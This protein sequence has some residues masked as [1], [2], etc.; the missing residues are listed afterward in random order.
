MTR[1][2]RIEKPPRPYLPPSMAGALTALASA[3]G[4]LELGWREYLGDDAPSVGFSL[5]LAA[6]LVALGLLALLGALAVRRARANNVAGG[7]NRRVQP[8]Q[9]IAWMGIGLLVGACSA[10][11]G[12]TDRRRAL[13]AI[14]AVPA[15][16]LTFRIEADGTKNDYGMQYTAQ[17]HT[18][19]G[20]TVGRVRLACDEAFDLGTEVSVIGRTSKLDGSSWGRSRYMAGSVAEVRV[21]RI[22]SSRAYALNPIIRAREMILDAI[23]PSASA[24]RALIAGIVCGR[25]TELNALE[26]SDAFARTGTSHLV[27][28]SGSHLALVSALGSTVL[29]TL[30]ASQRTRGVLL[31]LLMGAYVLFTGGAAS[32]LRS[33][34]M[35][36][37]SLVA[38]LSG[39][40]SHGLS[41][42]A[43]SAIGLVFLDAGIAYDL[44]FQLSAMS[45]LFIQLFGR[46]LTY[47]I[48]RL[49]APRTLAEA[50]ALTVSAQ[51]A[52]LPLT[53]PIFGTCS[54]VAPIANLVLGPIMSALLVV[55]LVSMPIV[56][57]VPLLAPCMIPAEWL[58]Q[59]S[60][61][62]AEAF[63]EVP[64]ASIAMAPSAL[65]APA[66][67]VTAAIVYLLW[68]DVRRRFVLIAAAVCLGTAGGY[69]CF[70]TCFAP[71]SITVLDVGQADAILIR[72]GSSAVLV[73]AGVDEQVVS[74]LA[75]NAVFHLDAV[76]ITHWDRDHCGGLPELLNTVPVDSVMV[77]QGAR[78]GMPEDLAA[79]SLPVVQEMS[80]G[81]AMIVGEFTCEMVW[82]RAAVEGSE[83][84]ESLVLVARYEQAERQL[85]VVLTGDTEA[86]EAIAY[87]PIVGDIDVLKIGH[88]GSSKSLNAEVLGMLDPEL[89]IASAGAD[90]AYGHPTSACME[91]V[92]QYG[93]RFLCTKD[94]GDV[95]VEPDEDGIRVH[96]EQSAVAR[97]VFPARLPIASIASIG[98]LVACQA[99]INEGAI[100]RPL[101]I[102]RFLALRRVWEVSAHGGIRAVARL[103]DRW[104]GRG[105]TRFGGGALEE[106]SCI[107]R[108]ARFQPR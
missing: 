105:Q 27:A 71:P 98:I 9:M 81:D 41:G 1:G 62:L 94:V 69:V 67:Y 49:G 63:S 31:A 107:E 42:L 96:V 68:L 20:T 25:T 50:L 85:A 92:A 78:A 79:L 74:A 61:F 57:F 32:A 75:R 34:D 24:A 60:V 55:G 99:T 3:S 23:D 43:L 95:R 80:V 46:Y 19:D 101:N 12:V 106:S 8:W 86:D 35:V 89:A 11:W 91:A 108:N 58:A 44:G 53:I 97:E 29:S 56:A 90:N 10:A 13:E 47:G 5:A 36:V 76:V 7:S 73:D 88:H 4:V 18:L 45:V 16:R 72:D 65:Y 82:P 104:P 84:E 2:S 48:E 6:V 52:T 70:W 87:A 83:N 59:G 33:F 66:F 51:W 22:C 100:G 26:E 40:R 37:L 64:G 93:A 30:G 14:A 103:P 77:A 15:S 21:I 17:A 28:V 38:S 39:R 102:P 54:L